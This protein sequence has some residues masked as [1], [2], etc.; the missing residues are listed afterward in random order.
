[1]KVVKRFAPKVQDS[2]WGGALKPGLGKDIVRSRPGRSPHTPT[3][4]KISPVRLVR[5]ERLAVESLVKM[6]DV[7]CVA[8][9]A[10]S[11]LENMFP[12]AGS[13]K[14][15]QPHEPMCKLLK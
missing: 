9:L 13:E 4:P 6:S 15:L 5:E 12:H 11:V 14:D 2:A 3:K 8:Y 1:M 10:R 7:H